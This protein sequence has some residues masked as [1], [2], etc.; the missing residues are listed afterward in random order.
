MAACVK[1]IAATE[2]AMVCGRV[3]VPA[4]ARRRSPSTS[5][6]WTRVARNESTCAAVPRTSRNSRLAGTASTVSPASATAAV[7]WSTAACVGENRAI[8]SAGAR[9]PR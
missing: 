4:G 9:N 7:T 2:R 3:A 8:Q 5:Y 6:V 1:V